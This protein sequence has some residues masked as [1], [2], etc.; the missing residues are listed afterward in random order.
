[1]GKTMFPIAPWDNE[2]MAELNTI[3]KT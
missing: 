1:M 3:I 2:N